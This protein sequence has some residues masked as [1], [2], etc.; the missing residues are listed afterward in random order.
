MY[1]NIGWKRTLTNESKTGQKYCRFRLI[2]EQNSHFSLEADVAALFLAKGK[3]IERSHN[4]VQRADNKP[5]S[6]RQQ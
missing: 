2:F 3:I 5:R 1:F 6:W 4:G